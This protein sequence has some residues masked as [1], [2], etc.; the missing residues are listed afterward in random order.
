MLSVS[1]LQATIKERK[2]MNIKQP[3]KNQRMSLAEVREQIVGKEEMGF[4][5]P[6]LTFTWQH[7]EEMQA[8]VQQ[9]FHR[10]QRAIEE[11][12]PEKAVLAVREMH[13]VVADLLTEAGASAAPLTGPQKH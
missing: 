3:D 1:I 9:N 4:D 12:R 8:R 2:N 7:W 13:T 5:Q 6:F 10:F 11:K